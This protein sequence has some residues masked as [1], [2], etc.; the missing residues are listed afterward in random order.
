MNERKDIREGIAFMFKQKELDNEIKPN[1]AKIA[2]EHGCDWRT[3]KK[4]YLNKGS[5][6]IKND[7]KFTPS[8]L[9]PYKQI[10]LEKFDNGVPATGIYMF[11]NKEKGYKGSYSLIT[12]FLRKEQRKRVHQAIIRFETEPGKQAQVD[13]KESL[14]FKTKNGKSIKFNIFLITLGFSRMRFIKVTESRSQQDVFY[15][16][17]RAFE[18]FGGVPKEILFD[19]MRSIT[20]KSRTTYDN[21]VYNDTFMEFAK[22]AGFIPKNCVAYRPC[23]K[24]KVESLARLMNRL[25]AYSG[26]IETYENIEEI[27]NEFNEEINNEKHQGTGRIPKELFLKEKEHL[28][29]LGDYYQER[30]ME[31]IEPDQRRKVSK[32]SLFSYKGHKYSVPPKYVEKYIFIVNDNGVEFDITDEKGHWIKHQE[33]GSKAINYSLGDYLEISKNSSIKMWKDEDLEKHASEVL[34]IYDKL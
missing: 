5:L 29:P 7:I 3:V 8:K 28:L 4:Y 16:L 1:Y 17:F 30:I 14:V 25:K 34:G 15:C 12:K 24:G 18:Y 13:W 26:E 31:F 21:V 19:N 22:S 20:D 9:D 27:V 23:T 32:E 33:Y 2:R 11:I 10:I 6:P